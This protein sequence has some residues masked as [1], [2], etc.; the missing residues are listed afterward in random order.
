MHW[1]ASDAKFGNIKPSRRCI[2]QRLGGSH[3]SIL[4]KFDLSGQVVLITGGSG[5]LGAAMAQAFAEAGADVAL[6]GRNLKRLERAA[7]AVRAAG[8]KAAV[9]G[10]EITDPAEPRRIVEE[11]IRQLGGLTNLINN[12]GGLSRRDLVPAT[13]LATDDEDWRAMLDL[14]LNSAVRMTKAAVSVMTSGSVIFI[15]S[16]TASK[17]RGS[18]VYGLAKAALNHLT[19]ALAEDLAP[20]IRV[21]AIAPGPI[22]TFGFRRLNNVAEGQD[23]AAIAK[24]W[25]IPLQ[26][27]GSED[28]ISAA[29]I[30]LSSPGAA[31]ITG[32][33]LLVAGGL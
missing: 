12:A 13:S 10:A 33:T 19:V 9:V 15:S 30:F 23:T 16:I 20:G 27:L 25:R 28:D 5:G 3:I 17:P 32:Q 1:L 8:R 31:W 22:A 26:R 24:K 21:N 11:T 2:D 29:A 7:D 6:T 18:G 4:E 14:N